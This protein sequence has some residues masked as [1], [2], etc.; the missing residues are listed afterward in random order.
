MFE[1]SG[2]HH[3]TT[4]VDNALNYISEI[5]RPGT[6]AETDYLSFEILMNNIVEN[7]VY[8]YT[9]SLTTPPCTEEV[10]WFVSMAPLPISV[11]SY[12]KLKKVL[13]FNSRYTQNDL[14]EENPLANGLA[15]G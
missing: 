3:S 4:F 2:S 10:T 9:G 7:G 1:L 15:A 11:G 12:E 5:E 8:T 6:V 13:R 14:G